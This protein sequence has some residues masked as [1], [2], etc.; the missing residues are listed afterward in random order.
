VARATLLH[1]LCV[2]NVVVRRGLVVAGAGT[3]GIALL[4]LARVV[5]LLGKLVRGGHQG[6]G[7]RL[8]PGDVVALE[9]VLDLAEGLFDQGRKRPLPSLPRKIG[10]VTSLDG[11]AI[12]DIIKVLRR[13]YPNA[14]IVIRRERI[15]D[16]QEIRD[17][18]TALDQ[19]DR[20][21]AALAR[22]QIE[23]IR[24]I[25]TL[26]ESGRTNDALR[27]VLALSDATAQPQQAGKNL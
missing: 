26:L 20:T 3:P 1:D 12:R 2:D 9:G 25:R 17:V 13:R 11:A 21:N 15:L 19:L 16:D 14:Q 10:I 24:Q 27:Y 18:W 7:C 6:I 8:D 23:M 22:T 4:A 5:D